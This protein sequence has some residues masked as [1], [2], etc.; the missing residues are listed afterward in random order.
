MRRFSFPPLRTSLLTFM[1]AAAA[2]CGTDPLDVG[3]PPEPG[4]P[5]NALPGGRD[6]T[7]PA[8]VTAAERQTVAASNEF[9]LSLFRRVNAR[10]AGQNVFI[11][12]YSAAVAL[13]MTLN[14][15]SGS[16]AAAM[17]STLGFGDR[18][19]PEIDATYRALAQRLVDA[20]TAVRFASA[21]SIWYNREIPFHHAF[22][23]TTAR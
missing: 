11:S 3:A 8:A 5:G 10:R 21:N 7:L 18:P 4:A 12:P 1:L 14:G 17:A 13:G 20:D 15:A 2:G 23:D 22:F 16:T 9:G 19:L 6:S